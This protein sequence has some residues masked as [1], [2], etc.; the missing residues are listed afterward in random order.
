M[1]T[2]RKAQLCLPNS[3]VQLW[4]PSDLNPFRSPD[5]LIVLRDQ[6]TC[7]EATSRYQAR[8]LRGQPLPRRHSQFLTFVED[9]FPTVELRGLDPLHRYDLTLQRVMQGQRRTRTIHPIL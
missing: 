8:T 7:E 2:A 6:D 1:A 4:L 3:T 5:L 9:V